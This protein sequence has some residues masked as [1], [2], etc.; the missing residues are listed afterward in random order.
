MG[1]EKERGKYRQT[2]LEGCTKGPREWEPVEKY[3]MNHLLPQGW[4][5]EDGPRT[6]LPQIEMVTALTEQ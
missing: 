1:V 2:S 4:W 3:D 6:E 5:E